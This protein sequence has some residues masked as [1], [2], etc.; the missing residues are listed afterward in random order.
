MAASLHGQTADD[1][2]GEQASTVEPPLE[3]QPAA[4]VEVAPVS[5]DVDIAARLQKILTATKWFEEPSVEVSE[6]VVFLEGTTT[7][8]ERKEWATKLASNTQ[9]VVAVANR[10]QVTES[11]I[12]DFSPAWKE[13]DSMRRNAIQSLPTVVLSLGILI[14]TWFAAKGFSHVA[15]GIISRRTGNPLLRDVS[16]KVVTVP[17]ILLGIYLALRVTG[18]TSIAATVLG[19]T[20]LLGLIIGIAFRD[21]AEN[22]LAS[23]LISMQ[24]PF[25]AGDNIVVEGHTGIVQAVTTRGTTIMTP[26]G[27]HV[28]IPNSIIYK[29]VIE[30]LTANPKQRESFTLSIDAKGSIS[31]TQ[32]A[33]LGVLQDHE[34]VLN[35]PEPLVLVQQLGRQT[36]LLRVYFWFDVHKHSKDKVRSALIRLAKIALQDLSADPAPPRSSSDVAAHEQVA[37]VDSASSTPAEGTLQ[38]DAPEIEKQARDSRSVEEGTDLLGN[39]PEPN[40]AKIVA[41]T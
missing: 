38:S 3:N 19:G 13:I 37:E 7:T 41:T 11:S 1:T 24:R 31:E 21:I 5:L 18:L 15:R 28:R 23:L 16:T 17:V 35:E 29:S 26:D 25:R 30:N 40:S 8:D 33:V 34:A 20:G 32:S 4:K 10:I 2:P 22:F 27:N 12:W 14:L 36:A 6:G 9:D 39:K